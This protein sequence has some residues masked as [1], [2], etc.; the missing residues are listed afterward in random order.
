MTI[1]ATT[2][3]SPQEACLP[4]TTTPPRATRSP[5]VLPRSTSTRCTRW[6]PLVVATRGCRSA[7]GS[8]SRRTGTASMRGA[9][10]KVPL[11]RQGRLPA[12]HNRHI[13][14]WLPT[15]HPTSTLTTRGTPS[16]VPPSLDPVRPFHQPPR[17]TRTHQQARV[18]VARQIPPTVKRGVVRCGKTSSDNLLC[19][20]CLP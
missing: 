17:T 5:P 11:A 14:P 20:S 18:V 16:D 19:P 12:D 6:K 1:L 8:G 10:G 7:R 13:P 4:T 3:C 2:T 9:P 15:H